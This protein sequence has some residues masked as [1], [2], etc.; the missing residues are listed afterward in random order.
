ML[1]RLDMRIAGVFLALLLAVQLA[2]FGLI[3]E[4]ISLNARAT[5]AEDLDNGARLIRRLLDQHNQRMIESARVLAADFGFRS[6]IGSGDRATLADT[7]ENHGERI[8]AAEMLFL[9][10]DL[11]LQAATARMA[12]QVYAYARAQAAASRQSDSARVVMIRG[13]PQLLLTVPIKAP[14]TIGYV[15]MGFALDKRLLDDMHQLAGIITSVLVRTQGGPWQ[16]DQ[17]LLE[18]ASAGDL[19]ARV[20]MLAGSAS[21]RIDG[22]T[23]Q[24]RLIPLASD[25][26]DEVSALMMRSIDAALEPFERL[27]MLLL[28]IT[29]VGALLSGTAS[30]LTAR[31]VT[32]PLKAL[33]RSAERLGAGDYEAAVDT[34]GTDEVGELARRFDAM[35]LDL[36]ER[37]QRISRLA[38]WDR[39][40][41]LPNRERFNQLLAQAIDETRGTDQVLS[42]LMLDLDRFKHVNDVLGPAF[43]DRLLGE[44]AQ[45][46]RAH[47]V[48]DTDAVARIGGDEFALLLR[49]ASSREAAE[50]GHRILAVMEQPI[51]LDD[52]TVDLRA[53]IGAVTHPAD[54]DDADTLLRRV[55]MAMYA[56][57]TRQAGLVHYQPDMDSAS[58]QSLSMLTDLREAVEQNQ[59]QL[60]LQPKID[61]ASGGVA[62]AEA[63][64]RWRHPVRGLVP[65]AHF[66]PFAEQTGAI[67]QITQWMIERTA[68]VLADLHSQGMPI[69]IA[70]NLS[71]RDLMD[72]QLPQKVAH[73]LAV[74]GLGP[75]ALCLEI[76]ESAIMDDPLRAEQ[77]LQGLHDMGVALSI[78]DFGTGYSS[79]AYLK[80]LPVDQLKI[81]RSFVMN[82]ERDRADVM[83]VRSTIDLAHNLGLKVVAEGVETEAQLALLGELG[84]DEAQG[85][86]LGRP[87]PAA[88]F[89]VWA[90]N[91]RPRQPAAGLRPA[92]AEPPSAAS[93]ACAAILDESV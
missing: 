88:E 21:A 67:R 93:N 14:L 68:T 12:P 60:Y 89:A 43:G 90:R 66:I 13:T 56:A 76:T 20:P 74:R 52:H 64:V 63:L 24:T 26:G 80:R 25:G 75:A 6:A 83:I 92:L 18:G 8:G 91:W 35:R 29:L 84:C 58:E 47:A 15:A 10:T 32:G 70:V 36:R 61:L 59:L 19:K 5:I 87:M 33:T 42:V 28:L 77:T 27:Q 22:T 82:M 1:N 16:V 78:D 11:S 62:G 38:Y 50:V 30:F 85:Y 23:Y 86:L 57:K 55:E 40:T 49:G 9:G 2:G 54:G 44:V 51:T 17:T 31:R 81:D 72:Q 79:L 7:L 73:Q 39:L 45:R 48:R 46:L 41:G 69:R 34:R 65:P 71:T 3:R 53:G 4:V 37:D